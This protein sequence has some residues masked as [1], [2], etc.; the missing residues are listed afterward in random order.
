MFCKVLSTFINQPEYL[1]STVLIAQRVCSN[2]SKHSCSGH[3]ADLDHFR[4]QTSAQRAPFTHFYQAKSPPKVVSD[5]NLQQ[6]PLLM[7]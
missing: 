5:Q 6:V 1:A 7:R 4:K 2:A 3:S